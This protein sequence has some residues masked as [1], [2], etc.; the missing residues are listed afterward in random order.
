MTAVDLL[1]ILDDLGEEEFERFQWILLQVESPKGFPTIKKSR[2]EKANKC[3]TVDLLVQTYELPGAVEVTKKVLKKIPRNDL[4]QRLS[5]TRSGSKGQSQEEKCEKCDVTQSEKYI[6]YTAT[7]EKQAAIIVS[8]FKIHDC[9]FSLLG[10]RSE[11][12]LVS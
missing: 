5:L 11:K 8:W 6:Y 7:E 12:E 9:I 2:L 3:D 4:V 10:L 1:D